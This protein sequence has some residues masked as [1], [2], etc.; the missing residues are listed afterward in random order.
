M[1]YAGHDRDYIYLKATPAEAAALSAV[2]VQSKRQWKLP[3]NKHT[4][5]TLAYKCPHPTISKLLA[6][7][8][9]RVAVIKFTKSR[10]SAPTDDTRLRPYQTVDISIIKDNPVLAIFNEQRTGKTP[11]ILKA[12]NGLK[13]GVIVCPSSLKLNWLKEM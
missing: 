12:L 10:E 1:T 2:Y 11:T 4:L 5:T 9:E 13:K 6:E 7:E 3:L 8:V